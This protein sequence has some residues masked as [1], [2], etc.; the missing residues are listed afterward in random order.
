MFGQSL[1]QVQAPGEAE[2]EL[3]WMSKMNLL[4]A[5]LTED[6]D[7]V[8]F[9]ASTILRVTSEGGSQ[10]MIRMYRAVDIANHPALRFNT[11]D[12]VLIALLAGGDYGAGV[13]GCGIKTAVALAHAGLGRQLVAG[14]QEA[15]HAA[16]APFLA[17]WRLAVVDELRTN[18]SGHLK[19][20]LPHVA[21]AV[22]LDF[23]NIAIINLYLHPRTSEHADLTEL[24]SLVREQG[25]DLVRL[26]RFAETH[27]LWGDPEGIYRAFAT[28]IFPGLAMR[29]LISA[30]LCAD[31]GLAPRAC[32]MI[33]TMVS[34]R[35]ES[36]SSEPHVPEVRV[37][38]S[39]SNQI[40]NTIF[41]VRRAGAALDRDSLLDV[42]HG[43]QSQLSSM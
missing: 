17:G 9:G 22:P 38:L 42:E 5:I 1:M 2:A 32:P 27:F 30:A 13:Q 41:D 34:L 39:I 18:A 33:G 23:P 31:L 11:A 14:I 43:C 40:I 16:T 36:Q 20:R 37:N 21:E 25:P 12:L 35:R 10:E 15:E 8:I 19:H 24:P 26:T 29:Q 28:K 7:A 4:D 3:A 6:S